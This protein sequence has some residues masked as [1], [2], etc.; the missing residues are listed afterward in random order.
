MN[1][2]RKYSA[3]RH[4][5][6]KAVKWSFI[7]N[8]SFS[9]L[10]WISS[11]CFRYFRSTRYTLPDHKA[12]QWC[13]SCISIALSHGKWTFSQVLGTRFHL[14][15]LVKPGSWSVPK[16][17]RLYCSPAGSIR[18][19]WVMSEL[20]SIPTFAAGWSRLSWEAFSKYYEQL[21]QSM[22]AKNVVTIHW[23]LRKHYKSFSM[24]SILSV[25]QKRLSFIGRLQKC[26]SASQTGSH[27][28]LLLAEVC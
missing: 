7:L 3:Q 13:A 22:N 17:L 12:Y 11:T 26:M 1:Y 27:S 2:A 15:P 28:L 21:S 4:A 23:L 20:S 5:S 14:E 16:R 19:A 10:S 9:S 6:V 24:I 18:Q 25:T 8:S